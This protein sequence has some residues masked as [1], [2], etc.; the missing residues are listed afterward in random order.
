M[1][2]DNQHLDNQHQVFI[3]LGS[4]IEPREKRLREAVAKLQTIGEIVAASSV[5]ETTPVGY[6][7]QPNFYNGVVEITTNLEPRPLIER[8]RKFET[9][10]GRTPRA[11]WHERE[12][13]FDILF[14]EDLVID[15]EGLIVPHPE[16]QNRKF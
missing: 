7:S 6:S 8:L 1:E 15:E 12:I 14:Y 9:E 16:L 3:A 5:F 13:D 11:R 10:L 2:L 4:N